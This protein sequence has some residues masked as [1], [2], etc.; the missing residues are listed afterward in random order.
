MAGHGI[1]GIGLS[2]LL[3]C[4]GFRNLISATFDVIGW[5]CCPSYDHGDLVV[6]G[7]LPRRPG[8]GVCRRS[9]AIAVD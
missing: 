9:A 8:S 2:G 1:D 3:D 6:E 5:R 4:L 7:W